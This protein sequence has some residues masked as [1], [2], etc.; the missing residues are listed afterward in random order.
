[1]SVSLAAIHRMEA[2]GFR[3]ESFDGR[4]RVYPAERL[5]AE[6]R[7]WITANKA[8]LILALAVHSDTTIQELLALFG[9]EIASAT[10]AT[11]A[12]SSLV[13]VKASQEPEHLPFTVCPVRQIAAHGRVCCAECQ[14]S[15]QIPDSDA[16]G[17]RSCGAGQL[18]G[19]GYA[20]HCCESYTAASDC[21]EPSRVVTAPPIKPAALKC[22]WN[23]DNRLLTK[24]AK[25][26]P[27]ADRTGCASCGAVKEGEAQH[28]RIRSY[29][30]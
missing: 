8:A 10:P 13:S 27:N 16:Y 23:N 24:C 9:A 4:L 29:A 17:W 14:H 18:G 21:I 15:A 6:Q 5:S 26:A 2:A 25:P 12:P 1:M 19:F 11:G 28:G 30:R 3:M 7:K 22:S 20:L